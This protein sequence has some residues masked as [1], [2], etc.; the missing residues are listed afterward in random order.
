MLQSRPDYG[1]D[2]TLCPLYL[3]RVLRRLYSSSHP[4]I[5]GTWF[6]AC[7]STFCQA[8]RFSFTVVR[9]IRLSDLRK[10]S[11]YQLVP[12]RG[13]IH[14]YRSWFRNG[15]YSVLH[16]LLSVR[17]S[18]DLPRLTVA[19]DVAF[20]NNDSL[21]PSLDLLLDLVACALYL[22]VPLQ[23]AS[24]CMARL[25]RRLPRIHK[26]DVSRQFS[27]PCQLVDRILPTLA[28][29]NYGIQTKDT[30]NTNRQER[31]R[32]SSGSLHQY[33]LQ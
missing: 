32:C 9:S 12:R 29:S 2:Q 27:Y 14:R 22:S 7:C 28:N 31:R 30:R 17:W 11:S 33:L 19:H 4:R 20:R 10:L 3:H 16:P 24:V 1:L 23:P 25:L 8:H 18:F 15:S 6:L 5:D 21:G 26:V 13:S